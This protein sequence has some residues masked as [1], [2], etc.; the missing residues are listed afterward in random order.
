MEAASCWRSGALSGFR[1]T[2]AGTAGEAADLAGV[3]SAL[4]EG[5]AGTRS[6]FSGTIA[7]PGA[8]EGDVGGNQQPASRSAGAKIQCTF[9]RL[10]EHLAF[11]CSIIRVP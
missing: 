3:G 7:E 11:L 10:S 6:A 5:A 4:A 9:G 8:A 1:P 2:V